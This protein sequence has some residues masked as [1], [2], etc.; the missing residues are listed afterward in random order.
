MLTLDSLLRSIEKKTK[1]KTEKLD[2]MPLEVSAR[3]FDDILLQL[4]NAVYKQ[5]IIE[6]STKDYMLSFHKEG[7]LGINKNYSFSC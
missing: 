7:D 5:N 3:K 2:K 4:S 1:L 6:K